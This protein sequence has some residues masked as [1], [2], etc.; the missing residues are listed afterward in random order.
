MRR[1]RYLSPAP[2]PSAIIQ[3]LCHSYE[4][5]C[6][7]I[8]DPVRWLIAPWARCNDGHLWVRPG[9]NTEALRV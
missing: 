4:C 1:P 6:M 7:L 3:L 9:S 2:D 8:R 5:P